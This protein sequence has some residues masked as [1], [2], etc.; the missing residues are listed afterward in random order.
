[1][2]MSL[3]HKKTQASIILTDERLEKFPLNARQTQNPES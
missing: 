1:M 3:T 2:K